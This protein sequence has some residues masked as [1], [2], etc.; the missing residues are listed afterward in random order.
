[1]IGVE[2]ERNGACAEVGENQRSGCRADHHC[3]VNQCDA[4]VLEIHANPCVRNSEHGICE[5]TECGDEDQQ[6]E[7]SASIESLDRDRDS[8]QEQEHR[9]RSDPHHDVCGTSRLLEPSAVREE[10]I[11]RNECWE[12][13]CEDR[14]IRDEKC[15]SIVTG[16]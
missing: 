9:H 13:E 7:S 2:R 5:Q 6:R 14:S 4:A 11:R 16:S 1:M 10:D 15:E 3:P 8:R 12:D